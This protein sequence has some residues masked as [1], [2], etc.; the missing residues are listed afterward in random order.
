MQILPPSFR[1]PIRN[2]HLKRQSQYKAYEW[3]ALLHWYILPIAT[4]LSINPLVIKN[5]SHLWRW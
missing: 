1:G 3:M 4:E 2:P 5:F